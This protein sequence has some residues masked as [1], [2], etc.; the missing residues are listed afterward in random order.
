MHGRR[1]RKRSGSIVHII[2]RNGYKLPRPY[3]DRGTPEAYHLRVDTRSSAAAADMWM[4]HSRSSE[5]L[6]D[7]RLIKAVGCRCRGNMTGRPISLS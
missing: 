1:N 7:I 3:N 4:K 5:L 6:F 2:T